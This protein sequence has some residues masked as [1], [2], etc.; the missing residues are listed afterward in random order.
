MENKEKSQKEQSPE[1]KE[2]PESEMSAEE[3]K[4]LSG[5]AGA[6]GTLQVG[7]IIKKGDTNYQLREDG[8]LHRLPNPNDLFA[9]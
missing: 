3:M 2:K 5:G 1:N 6:S 9:G 8:K 7:D 4:A